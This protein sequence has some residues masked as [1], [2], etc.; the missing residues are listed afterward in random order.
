MGYTSCLVLSSV[1]LVVCVSAC[2][3]VVTA[4]WCGLFFINVFFSF[5]FSVVI[6]ERFHVLANIHPC[7]VYCVFVAIGCLASLLFTCNV[8][9]CCCCSSVPSPAVRRRGVVFTAD[10]SIILRFI[11]RPIIMAS[12]TQYLIVHPPMNEPSWPVHRR[13]CCAA[14]TLFLRTGFVDPLN[15]GNNPRPP[16]ILMKYI[17]VPGED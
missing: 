14:F 5:C 1:C 12:I 7:M 13:A 4:C 16:T 3:D 2:H 17:R 11:I 8:N 10:E 9:S 15:F 6:A